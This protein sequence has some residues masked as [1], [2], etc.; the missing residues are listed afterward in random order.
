MSQTKN[1][2]AILIVA[3]VFLLISSALNVALM[4]YYE[5]EYGYYYD[6]IDL[7]GPSMGVV[8]SFLLMIGFI[9]LHGSARV[10]TP[11]RLCPKC[12]RNISADAKF[13]PFCGWNPS[14]S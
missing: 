8:A 1:A 3:S 10:A 13:C 5:I 7:I 14:K 11:T 2:A 4:F 6:I 9:V 12:G